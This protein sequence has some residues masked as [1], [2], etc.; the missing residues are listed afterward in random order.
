[1]TKLKLAD[2]TV[3]TDVSSVPSACFEVKSQKNGTI[4]LSG[5]GFGHGIGMS[6][7]GANAMGEEGMSWQEILQFYYHDVKIENIFD[8]D[9][10][11]EK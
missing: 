6:Q 1:M 3:R 8:V 5:G 4:V 2:G 9:L 11:Q 10:E 7:Y